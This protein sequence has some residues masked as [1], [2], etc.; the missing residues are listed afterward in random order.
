M[1]I[2]LKWLDIYLNLKD[3]KKTKQNVKKK[4]KQ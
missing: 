1:F 3:E 4:T 2:N